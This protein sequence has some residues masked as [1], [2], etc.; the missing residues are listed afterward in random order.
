MQLYSAQHSSREKNFTSCCSGLLKN[1]F[2][3]KG[4]ASFAVRGKSTS[5]GAVFR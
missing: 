4:T 2:R 3:V 1:N 5:A